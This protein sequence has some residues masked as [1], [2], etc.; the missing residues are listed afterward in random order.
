MQEYSLR[1]AQD[2]LPELIADAIQ[3]KIVR[4]EGEGEGIVQLVPVQNLQRERKAGS[5]R[6]QITISPD[7]DAPLTD[8]QKYME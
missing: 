5:A 1:D 4:I 6:G 2:R 8:F 3:G 7:F